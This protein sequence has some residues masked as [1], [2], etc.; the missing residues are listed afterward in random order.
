M[1]QSDFIENIEPFVD[2]VTH[3]PEVGIGLGVPRQTVRIV[4]KGEERRLQ[5]W[6]HTS[7][8]H[9]DRLCI[10]SHASESIP[11]LADYQQFHLVGESFLKTDPCVS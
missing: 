3:C 10:S 11:L 9:L 7:T 8:Y 4:L 1:K 5:D 2:F 6:L